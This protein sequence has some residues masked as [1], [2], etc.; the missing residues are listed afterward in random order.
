VLSVRHQMEFYFNMKFKCRCY[1]KSV[2]PHFAIFVPKPYGKTVRLSI[3]RVF[4]LN[5]SSKFDKIQFGK[6][7]LFMTSRILNCCIKTSCG[8]V[9]LISLK[10][11]A[12]KNVARNTY[13]YF[14]SCTVTEYDN[15]FTEM[16]KI[17]IYVQRTRVYTTVCKVEDS[18]IP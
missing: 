10:I 13:K 2:V 8:K 1:F 18:E 5:Y 9:C 12:L 7:L 14:M 11:T 17:F 16:W 3:C 6:R 4:K 15:M